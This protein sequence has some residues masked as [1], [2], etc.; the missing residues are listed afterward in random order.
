MSTLSQHSLNIIIVEKTG[1][2]KALNIKDFKEDEL[3]KKCGFKK[4]TDFS[5]QTEWN[6]KMDGNKY[7]V[8]VYAKLDGR[9]NSENKYDFPPPIDNKLFF[10]NCAIVAKK[11]DVGQDGT[12]M[13]NYVNLTL[14]LWGKIYEKL[15][16]GFEDLALTALD[17]ENEIDELKNVPKDKKTK[18]GY[19][20]D[21]FV[22]DSSET[23]ESEYDGSDEDDDD[24]EECDD[25]TNNDE[26]IEEDLELEEDIGS[27]LSEDNYDYSSDEDK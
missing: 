9:A 4:A 22:V 10:G 14:E 27:E 24:E 15:F 19:L 16:G 8:H 12:S 11:L 7:T 17:D 3:Y 18:T 23:D 13:Y 5:K 26:K 6:V 2:L 25:E 20:K 21:G 1:E